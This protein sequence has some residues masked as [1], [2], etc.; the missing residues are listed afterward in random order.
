MHELYKMFERYN[1]VGLSEGIKYLESLND[2]ERAIISAC[3][4]ATL[5]N[6]KFAE[7][8]N[9]AR[10]TGNDEAKSH[11]MGLYGAISVAGFVAQHQFGNINNLED[12][13]SWSHQ[14]AAEL[15]DSVSTE[16]GDLPEN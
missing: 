7:I 4:I 15:I 13:K 6:K 1:K 5:F 10:E 14:Y 12:I 8:V 2:A 9:S 16:A 11:I 3:A